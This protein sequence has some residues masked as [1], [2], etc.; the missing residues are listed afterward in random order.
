VD[1]ILE[2]EFEVERAGHRFVVNWVTTGMPCVC[3][4][5]DGQRVFTGEAFA[6]R[7]ELRATKAGE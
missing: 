2:D 5:V 3:S 1:R 4:V 6:F 7:R